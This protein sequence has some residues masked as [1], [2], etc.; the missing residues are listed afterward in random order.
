MADASVRP[1]QHQP[2]FGL[3]GAFP[4]RGRPGFHDVMNH[5]RMEGKKILF[6]CDFA[7]QLNRAPH[8]SNHIVATALMPFS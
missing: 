1:A 8:A 5:Q 2:F 3:L 7:G 6:D 4:G